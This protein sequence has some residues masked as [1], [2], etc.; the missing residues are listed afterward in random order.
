MI[1]RL[2]PIALS[3]IVERNETDYLYLRLLEKALETNSAHFWSND[4]ITLLIGGQK[5]QFQ[6]RV[7]GAKIQPLLEQICPSAF[8]TD[9]TNLSELYVKI[10]E[11]FQAKE[12]E[13]SPQTLFGLKSTLQRDIELGSIQIENRHQLKAFYF[14][15]SFFDFFL[16]RKT[17]ASLNALIGEAES[18]LLQ[19]KRIDLAE[20]IKGIKERLGEHKGSLMSKLT[21]SKKL[22][23]E[24]S[25]QLC[26]HLSS[27]KL[28][29]WTG[30]EIK[31][32]ASGVFELL[33]AL[34]NSKENSLALIELV[35]V[36][37]LLFQNFDEAGNSLREKASGEKSSLSQ[38]Y[39]VQIESLLRF[40][41]K[42]RAE[43]RVE[44]R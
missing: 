30:E 13:A 6:N 15:L 19:L 40:R 21:T 29:D 2:M 14:Y 10:A 28:S 35:R 3:G 43:N 36:F 37:L 31:D 20:I 12:N 33:V 25:R 5:Q 18:N 7:S 39:A 16:C 11:S 44:R 27:Q 26:S 1:D 9:E 17:S 41:K 34:Q 23:L 38:F 4:V 24:S 32:L 8:K 42:K 22:V